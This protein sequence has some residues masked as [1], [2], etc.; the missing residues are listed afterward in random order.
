MSLLLKNCKKIPA[1]LCLIFPFL[2]S[3]AQVNPVIFLRSTPSD[4]SYMAPTTLSFHADAYNPSGEI[5]SVEFY[6]C[7]T[8]I[9]VTDSEPYEMILKDLP[10]GHYCITAKAIG[11]L[12]SSTSSYAISFVVHAPE[13]SCG[14]FPTYE[15]NAGYAAG[16]QVI[17]NGKKYECKPYPYSG[18]CNGAAWAYEPGTGLYWQDA[19]IDLGTCSVESSP[20]PNCT[21]TPP[22]LEG[23]TYGP[24]SQVTYEG[25]R[26]ECK[27]WPYS[28]W[29]SQASWA[30]GPGSGM[31]WQDAWTALGTCSSSSLSK[32]VSSTQVI[33]VPQPFENNTKIKLETEEEIIAMAIYDSRGI[34]VQSMSSVHEKGIT[35]GD[36][37]SSGYYILHL[38]TKTAVYTKTLIKR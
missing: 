8:K 18:W 17:D 37:L 28:G 7:T 1:L 14:S 27:P 10:A 34:E 29:C 20:V 22:Y 32:S 21:N 11:D 2:T 38:T 30:Y 12:D 6:L 3:L 13:D 16:S 25:T 26:Y 9:A 31:Y 24:G 23:E 35:I 33:A 19:W 4:T 36:N 15:E 5:T